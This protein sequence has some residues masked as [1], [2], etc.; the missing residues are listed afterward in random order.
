MIFGFFSNYNEIRNT[1]RLMLAAAISYF[2]WPNEANLNYGRKKF[3]QL[4]DLQKYGHENFHK[5][6]VS[7]FYKKDL[8]RCNHENTQKIKKTNKKGFRSALNLSSA[9]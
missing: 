1:T 6:T 4:T 3:Y 9:T 5:C 7:L 8:S 2:F